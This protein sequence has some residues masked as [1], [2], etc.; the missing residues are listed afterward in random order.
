MF[1]KVVSHLIIIMKEFHEIF[2]KDV[3]KYLKNFTSTDHKL[4]GDPKSNPLPN[5][6]K[7]VL[8]RN[9]VCQ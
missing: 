1:L 9:K 8:N 3:L 2:Q 4:Q 6:Q 5:Y 7:I